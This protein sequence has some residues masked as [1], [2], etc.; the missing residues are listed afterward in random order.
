[1]RTFSWSVSA[2]A[3]LALAACGANSINTSGTTGGAGSGTT[4]GGAGTT[5]GTPPIDY[6]TPV[7]PQVYGINVGN[8][9]PNIALSGGAIANF[10]TTVTQDCPPGDK[11]TTSSPN[12]VPS[13][14]FQDLYF[15][16]QQPPQGNSF[17]YAFI[18]ISGAWCPH[19][20]QEAEDLPGSAAK[21]YSD[22]YVK[23]W[24]GEGGI[25]FSIIVQNAADNA[26]ATTDTLFTWI[27]TYQLDYPVSID[28]QENMV[29]RTGIRAWPG[30]VIVRLNDMQVIES[31]LGAGD[32]FYADFTK[33][34]TACQGKPSIPND[35]WAGATC[36]SGTCVAN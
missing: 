31:V 20:Q 27:N 12:F 17:R 35:C 15:A 2:I 19:C 33:A 30:N 1:M 24:L 21:A 32:S 36:Q 26:P 3:S 4:T 7:A 10:A 25:V 34:L 14:T 13:I 22:G 28:T 11:C 6:P 5:T 16:G 29:S 8:T 23:E 9:F 18:D